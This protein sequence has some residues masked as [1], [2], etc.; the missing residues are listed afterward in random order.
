MLYS[1]EGV[2][3]QHQRLPDGPP[4]P[5]LTTSSP[6]EAG[7]T[8]SHAPVFQPASVQTPQNVPANV[9][10]TRI[11]EADL[12][13]NLHSPYPA[14]IPRIPSHP[15]AS[16]TVP[17]TEFIQ[18]SP[19]NN[20]FGQFQGPAVMPYSGMMIESQDIDMSMLADD[21]MW[22]EYLPQD[23]KR[24]FGGPNAPS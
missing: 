7:Q 13:L 9:D 16:G 4:V 12:L 8:L 11:S 1:S 21:M 24:G 22:L 2:N 19:L 20:P 10:A 14:P 18:N 3:G 6:C 23:F 5:I 17:N 15:T